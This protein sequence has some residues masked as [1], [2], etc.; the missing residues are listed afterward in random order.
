[1]IR[2][3]NEWL[4]YSR[5]QIIMFEVILKAKQKGIQKN[6]LV[7][8]IANKIEEISTKFKSCIPGVPFEKILHVCAGWSCQEGKLSTSDDWR[9][10]L[11]LACMQRCS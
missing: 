9:H 10:D 11:F 5:L 6:E 4:L 3:V 8:M 7:K 1:M 2:F